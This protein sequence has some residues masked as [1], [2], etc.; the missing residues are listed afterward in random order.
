MSSAWSG[1]S[2]S[3]FSIIMAFSSSLDMFIEPLVVTF[4]PLTKYM[5]FIF[6]PCS[7]LYSSC[8]PVMM[9][10][11]FKASGLVM[12]CMVFSR[13]SSVVLSSI[14]CLMASLDMA[15]ASMGA[16]SNNWSTSSLLSPSIFCFSSP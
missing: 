13:F 8:E 9:V 10:L 14:C 3:T 15:C 2:F 11:P 5:R 16:C 6:M 12:F 7:F 4:L 1:T